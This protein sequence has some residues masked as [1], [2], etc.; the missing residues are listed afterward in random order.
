MIIDKLQRAE[1]YYLMNPYFKDAFQYVLNSNLG[2]M[3]PGKYDI[4]GDNSFLII[5]D[6]KPNPE[7]K[8]KLEAHQTYIDVQMVV[9]GSFNL[10]WKA[11][12]ECSEI[13]NE[14]NPEI[15][16]AFYTDYSDFEVVINPGTFVILF[17]EDAHYPQT[18]KSEIKKAILKIRN[19]N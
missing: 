15:D 19:V 14:Y 3:L 12:E 11:L 7:F 6:D 16:A 2:E 8:P 13:I 18:P 5:A 1:K 10:T 17:P 9:D 4:D